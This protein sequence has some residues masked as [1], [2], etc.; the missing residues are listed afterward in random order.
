MNQKGAARSGVF[1]GLLLIVFGTLLLAERLDLLE[2]NV[3]R[4]FWPLAILAVGINFLISR[5]GPYGMAFGAFLVLAGVLLELE[6]FG[7]VRFRLRDLW[8]I[9]LIFVGALLLWRALRPAPEHKSIPQVESRINE[10]AVFGGGDIK[11]TTQNFEGGSLFA[12]FGGYEIDFT[13]SKIAQSPAILHA[14]AIFGGVSMRVPQEWRVTA[15][16]SA[17]LGGFESKALPPSGD[18]EEQHLI[19]EGFTLFGGVEIKN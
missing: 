17:L 9:Y 8:P 12:M 7:V 6:K 4:H 3:L 10:F 11:V 19:V 13:N 5:R 2:T 18:G 1:F 14:D 16:G 15:R